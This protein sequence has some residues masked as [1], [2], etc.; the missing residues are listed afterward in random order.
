[1]ARILTETLARVGVI[2]TRVSAA[3]SESKPFADWRDIEAVDGVICRFRLHPTKSMAVM[4]L[5][6]TLVH[7]ITDSFYGGSGSDM[8]T[9]GPA[10]PAELRMAEKIG[11]VVSDALAASWADILHLAPIVDLVVTDWDDVEF[12]RANDPVV[13]QPFK[14]SGGIAAGN[15]ITL[16]YPADA[17]RTLSQRAAAE[18]AP[19]A[20]DTNPEW[21]DKLTSALLEMNLPLRAVFA[22]PEM[23]L[24][25]LLTLK[26]GDVFPITLPARVPV[27][28]AGRHFA[29]ATIGE[30][31]GRVAVQ[32]EA[33]PVTNLKGDQI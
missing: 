32:I 17:M 26:R 13:I 24:Q 31:N 27:T 2:G 15:E 23:P 5:P 6:S 9:A 19:A 29:E 18:E 28:V 10:S 12:L 22:R 33:M 30:A 20:D 4:L 21:R 1:M 16:L 14:L 3:G 7:Q 25:R 11:G 8:K